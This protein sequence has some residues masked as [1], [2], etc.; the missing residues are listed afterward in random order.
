VS[1]RSADPTDTD[2][3]WAAA[4]FAVDP[5][6]LGGVSLRAA[7]GPVRDGWLAGLRDLLPSEAAVRKLPLNVS[8]GRL[9]GGLDLTATLSAGRPVADRGFLAEA[10]GGVILVAMAERLPVMIAAHLAAALD[11][12]MIATERDGLSARLPA[13]IGIVALDEGIAEDE[14]PPAALLD[15]LAFHVELG[16]KAT[17][18][19]SGARID[20][21]AIEGARTLLPKV[22]ISE[23]ILRTLCAAGLALGV[24]SIRGTQL[25]VQ[26]AR[27]AA[28]LDGRHNVNEDDAALAAGLVL[29]P[30]ATRIPAEAEEDAG[31]AE[32]QESPPPS[33]PAE[34]D[35]GK[36]DETEQPLLDRLPEDMVL[37]ASAAAIPAGLLAQL[38]TRGTA[39][40]QSRAAGR[41]GAFAQ[42]SGRG[43]PAG[44]R[45]GMPGK[46]ARL[47]LIETLRAAAPWQGVRRAAASSGERLSRATE[48]CI[49]VRRDDW[50]VTRLKQRSE[51]AT[52]FVVDAS[53]SSA[54]HRL[55]EAK[56]AVELLL[57]DCYVRRD[58]V[59]LIAF[60]GKK[61]E[62]LL[63]PTRSLVRAKRSLAGLPGGGGTPLAAA[64]D[65]AKD[66]ADAL[67]RKGQTPVIVLLTDG[68]ANVTREGKGSRA[69][70]DA[71]ALSSARQLRG[72]GLTTIL[73]DTS[74]RASAAAE[75]LAQECAAQ[76]LALPQADAV[77]LSRSVQSATATARGAGSAQRR[78]VS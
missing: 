3:A 30:R 41:A 12:K 31:D 63:P 9:L 66:L 49:D 10:D 78:S 55:A 13:R 51:S 5:S 25:A 52:I 74:P 64:I 39:A 24:D 61:A 22:R 11:A 56:G 62:L 29:G 50:R 33:D 26:A 57:A 47:N 1:D 4:L 53:G 32:P 7:F 21:L 19:R 38:K 2:A 73:V 77:S 75:R 69:E 16:A 14:R 65:T 20:R 40:K 34:P 45:S 28:A 72:L 71:E 44:I 76:Y 42:G 15:R 67:R 17:L 23:E 58:R 43:R 59:A 48:R 54:L 27:V 6:G 35:D 70:A 68:R 36:L 37:A 8:E 60:R 18:D 46:G